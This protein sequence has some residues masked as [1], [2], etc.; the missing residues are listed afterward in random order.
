MFANL[1]ANT[2][3]FRYSTG[4]IVASSNVTSPI[5]HSNEM[6]TVASSADPASGHAEDGAR[7]NVAAPYEDF[8]EGAELAAGRRRHSFQIRYMS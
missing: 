2:E 7:A 4:V 1:L 8:E 5:P 3:M 6:A